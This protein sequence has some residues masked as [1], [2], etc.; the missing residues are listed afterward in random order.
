MH[1]TEGTPVRVQADD[2]EEDRFSRFHLIGWWEQERLRN[3]NV[4]VIGA[5]RFGNEILKN[6]ALLGVRRIL[7]VDFDRIE[8][9]QSFPECPVSHQRCRRFQGSNRG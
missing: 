5:G 8:V 4:L 9:L 6:L 7:I 1:E 2:L 3:A